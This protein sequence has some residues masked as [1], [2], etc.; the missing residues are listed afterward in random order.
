M[1]S[2]FEN[3][4]DGP[5]HDDEVYGFSKSLRAQIAATSGFSTLNTYINY[6]YGD[7]GPEVWFGKKHL[8]RL[9]KLKRKYDPLGKLGA[10]NPIP[11]SS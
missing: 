3:Y 10:G 9:E 1:R 6:A 11:L 8:P 7:E 4:Y 2:I 5:V